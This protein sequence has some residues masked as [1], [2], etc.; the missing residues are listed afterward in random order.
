MSSR[1][2]MK[3]D[4]ELFSSASQGNLSLLN[5]LIPERRVDDSSKTK[6]G[7]AA[8]RM[9]GV[10]SKVFRRDVDINTI[11]DDS[12][13]ILHVA[14]TSGYAEYLRRAIDLGARVDIV[15]RTGNTAL[16]YAAWGNHPECVRVLLE[17]GVPV[18]GLN[19]DQCSPL[20]LA[21]QFNRSADSA[22]LLMAAGASPLLQNR[23]G[24]TPLD[25]SAEYG[26][27]AILRL[28]ATKEV[29]DKVYANPSQPPPRSPL[30]LAASGGHADC[31]AV[32]L[33][34]GV[35]VNAMSH[36]GSTA[37]HYATERGKHAVVALL[38]SRGADI[39]AK[40][41]GQLTPIQILCATTNRL[42]ENR[43]FILLSSAT[44]G[45]DPEAALAAAGV[46]LAPTVVPIVRDPEAEAVPG[47]AVVSPVAASSA[48]AA[49]AAATAAAPGGP[50][51]SASSSVSLASMGSLGQSADGGGP[52]TPG[53]PVGSADPP[54]AVLSPLGPGAAGV[55][56][57]TASIASQSDA[58]GTEGA[59]ATGPGPA[60]SAASPSPAAAAAAPA[61]TKQPKVLGRAVARMSHI[62]SIYDA[63]A[64]SFEEGDE[65]EVH[66]FR[67][68][69]L[70]VGRLLRTGQVG[71]FKCNLVDVTEEYEEGDEEEDEAEQQVADEPAAGAPAAIAPLT[72]APPKPTLSMA[73]LV[74][75][76]PLA[77]GAP[78]SST[79]AASRLVAATASAPIP[80]PISAP[81]PV[82]AAAA[83][84]APSRAPSRH[85]DSS[86]SDYS[87]SS[88]YDSDYSGSESDS[89]DSDI[90]MPADPFGAQG[91]RVNTVA[92]TT[93]PPPPGPRPGAAAVPSNLPPAVGPDGRPWVDKWL[94]D[95]HWECYVGA[96][97]A[98]GLTSPADVLS[99][100]RSAADLARL[101][102]GITLAHHRSNLAEEVESLRRQY[103]DVAATTVPAGDAL[104]SAALPRKPQVS[105]YGMPAGFGSA[106]FSA[107]SAAEAAAGSNS[108]PC[109]SGGTSGTITNNGITL[110]KPPAPLGPASSSVPSSPI[111]L[112]PPIGGAVPDDMQ[113]LFNDLNDVIQSF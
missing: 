37:L 3:K 82:A 96:F 106:S 98:A 17:A 79:S 84:A 80:A 15:D 112:P 91:V 45:V 101:V 30:H 76:Q 14:A 26:K 1:S 67:P 63:L 66:D 8:G 71:E 59:L 12:M 22:Q 97:H 36:I 51:G 33:D 74:P 104:P 110:P 25:L 105:I 41:R 43:S 23:A 93:L 54:A 5:E 28:L 44:R 57:D 113:D 94:F 108:A 95:I 39:H 34:G 6:A 92:A 61:A 72:A 107:A 47:A 11:N 35:D 24:Q 73:G 109:S 83:A 75:P 38:L 68:S 102:P 52:S 48:G 62:G 53:R 99:S 85:S 40:N 31:V 10:L 90:D 9:T 50:L 7:G 2:R 70:W 89:S 60:M 86:G 87:S 42:K 13:T 18:D 65:F 32:L 56:S 77:A 78:A 69:G 49:A 88:E 27:D 46:S 19:N 103:G 81:A 20:H 21:A 4:D 58:S 29:L 100:I 16:H 111:D 55:L 64:L